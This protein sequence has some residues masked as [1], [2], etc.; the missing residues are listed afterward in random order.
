MD[1]GKLSTDLIADAFKNR[2]PGLNTQVVFHFMVSQ[3]DYNAETGQYEN[4]IADS[5]PIPCVA[6]RPTFD[7]VSEGQATAKD[8]KLLVPGKFLT[9]EIDDET[10]A[11]M[12]GKLWKVKKGKAVPGGAVVIAFL[13]RT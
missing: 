3:G 6:C 1:Y 13:Q 7:E 4:V 9:R 5:A 10:T 12:G 2:M 11:T 8:M